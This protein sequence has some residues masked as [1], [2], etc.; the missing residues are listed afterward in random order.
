MFGL[1]I[2]NKIDTNTGI[3]PITQF[4]F[5]EKTGCHWASL[6]KICDLNYG[7]REWLISCP[8]DEGCWIKSKWKKLHKMEDKITSTVNALKK[9]INE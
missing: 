2:S 9:Q 8:E 7:E 3:F 5:D 1:K 6:G 4:K